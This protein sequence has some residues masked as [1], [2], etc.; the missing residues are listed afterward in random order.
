MHRIIWEVYTS[1]AVFLLVFLGRTSGKNQ[2]RLLG[3]QMSYDH[4]L[5]EIVSETSEPCVGDCG[6]QEN[7]D[8]PQYAKETRTG[9]RIKATKNF[10]E[11]F[12]N[13]QNKK[14]TF[15]TFLLFISPY[16]KL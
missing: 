4:E 5:H 16:T 6:N 1:P 15:P 14:T 12:K 9:G 13:F 7:V 10:P 11:I 3:F 2:R 8:A